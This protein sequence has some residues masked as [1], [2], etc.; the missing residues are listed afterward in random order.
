M[1][2]CE[3]HLLASCLKFILDG[4]QSWGDRPTPADVNQATEIDTK[5]LYVV[6]DI[7]RFRRLIHRLCKLHVDD[8]YKK[9]PPVW[10]PAR[11]ARR[12]KEI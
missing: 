3:L 11:I 4:V 2:P 8:D 10:N 7:C 9:H 5:I 12:R 1:V 6:V